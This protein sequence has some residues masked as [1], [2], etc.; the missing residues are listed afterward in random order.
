MAE[1]AQG[2]GIPHAEGRRGKLVR[3]CFWKSARKKCRLI[4]CPESL[5]SSAFWRKMP[6][7]KIA[8]PLRKSPF[9]QHREDSQSSSR[10][11]LTASLMKKSRSAARPS[12]LLLMKTAIRPERHRALQ[13][14][15]ISIL[16]SL[17]GKANIHGLMSSMKA[18]RSKT[19]FLLFSR[20]SL[21]D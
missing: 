18:K 17:S 4:L 9:T 15:S 5:I 12:R 11:L 10:K 7:E 19:S 13:E 21:Q 6:S 1:E 14:D 8:F 3:I 2:T 20:P 16:P